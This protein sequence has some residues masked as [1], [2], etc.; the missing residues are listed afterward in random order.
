MTL[1]SKSASSSLA[2]LSSLIRSNSSLPNPE[3]ESLIERAVS[4]PPLNSN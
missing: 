3:R 2:L 4:F 1:S